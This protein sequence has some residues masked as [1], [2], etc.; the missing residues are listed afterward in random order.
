MPLPPPEDVLKTDADVTWAAKELAYVLRSSRPRWEQIERDFTFTDGIVTGC[1]S[2]DDRV[3]PSTM[4]RRSVMSPTW[5]T[6]TLLPR[7]TLQ[8]A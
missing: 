6:R 1:V 3:T 4:K 8:I 5:A 2:A 7:A